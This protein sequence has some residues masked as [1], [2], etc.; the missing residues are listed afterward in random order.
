MTIRIP[1]NRTFKVKYELKRVGSPGDAIAGVSLTRDG[2]VTWHDLPW[3]RIINPIVGKKYELTLK[4]LSFDDSKD[5][6]PPITMLGTYGGVSYA[7]NE[8]DVPWYAI[9]WAWG[10]FDD[11]TEYQVY[12][13]GEGKLLDRQNKIIKNGELVI[14]SVS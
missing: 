12:K 2:G 4:G 10:K 11:G 13:A 3:I 5:V 1:L 7:W 9:L 14:P 6:N 8:Y